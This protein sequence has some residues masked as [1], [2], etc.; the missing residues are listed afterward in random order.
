MYS[1][2][3]YLLPQPH[4]RHHI[5][6]MSS[7]LE[8]YKRGS[9]RGTTHATS[10]SG[11]TKEP[12]GSTTHQSMPVNPG[13]S[14]IGELVKYVVQE[15]E[16]LQ[17]DVG[18]MLQQEYKNQELCKKLPLSD[19][20]VQTQQV[21]RDNTVR[22]SVKSQRYDR[23][24]QGW[25][26]KSCLSAEEDAGARYDLAKSNFRS[27]VEKAQEIYDPRQVRDRILQAK[28]YSR[29]AKGKAEMASEA[30]SIVNS[31]F[32]KHKP[33]ETVSSPSAQTGSWWGR[34]S[35]GNK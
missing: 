7:I 15:C 32:Q 18:N 2:F 8:I 11:S 29:S 28:V 23:I 31:I 10:T 24:N 22:K 26:K 33:D 17:S 34:I 27:M 20:G 6:S 3:F 21:Q 35:S 9:T 13:Q 14:T 5:R 1:I 4:H 16:E 12:N 19:I 25:P 30:A